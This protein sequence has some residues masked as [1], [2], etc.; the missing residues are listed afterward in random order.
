MDS[1]SQPVRESDFFFVHSCNN[2]MEILTDIVAVTTTG[3]S[4]QHNVV[5]V[6]QCQLR[7]SAAD[8][9]VQVYGTVLFRSFTSDGGRARVVT[10]VRRGRRDH[11]VGETG[12]GPATVDDHTYVRVPGLPQD[13]QKEVAP[14]VAHTRTHRRAAAS[15]PSACGSSR[16][17]TN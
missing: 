7:A 6:V 13:V 17:P 4:F 16:G 1:L 10:V 12:A 3:Y 9:A 14:K 11:H 2:N 8:V 5:A 15:G